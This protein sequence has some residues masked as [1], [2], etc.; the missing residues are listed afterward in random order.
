MGSR[1]GS[2]GAGAS[3][4][5]SPSAATANPVPDASVLE[6]EEA[7]E[8]AGLGLNRTAKPKA[9]TKAKKT[10]DDLAKEEIA[11]LQAEMDSLVANLSTF[12]STPTGQNLGRVDRMINRTLKGFKVSHNYEGTQQCES[13]AHVLESIRHCCK[14]PGHH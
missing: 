10:S 14:A 4:P 3:Q 9:K 6:A 2:D 12:P 1:L 7:E 13:M 5:P 11:K 8:A